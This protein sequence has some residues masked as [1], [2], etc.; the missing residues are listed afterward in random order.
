MAGLFGVKTQST[1]DKRLNAIDV[2]QSAYGAVIAL[3]YG[4]TRVPINLLWY[5]SFVATPHTTKQSGGKGGG[6]GSSNT[7]FTYS[8]AMVL[9]LGEGQINGIGT[10]WA[11]KA[12]TTLTA[13][14]L[15]LFTG[16]GG[17]AVW[18]Y[19]TT[20]FPTQ[21]IGYDHTAYVASGS[22]QLGNSAAVPNLSFELK[23]LQLFNPGTIDDAEPSDVLIDYC[24]DANHGCGFPYLSGLQGAGVTTYESYCIAMGMFISPSE[25]TQRLASEFID[26]ILQITNS[27]AVQSPGQLRIVPYADA[28]VTGNGRTYTPDLTPL[29]SFNDDDF[30]PQED[31]DPVKVTRKPKIERFNVV[32]VEYLNRDNQYNVDV[33]EAKDQADI[34]VNGERVAPTINLHS[35]TVLALAR[36]VAQ[37]LLQRQLY[38]VNAYW[39]QVRADY[40]LLEPMDYVS[41]TD[42][43]LGLTNKLVRILEVEDDEDDVLTFDVE[44]VLVGTA[45]APRYN[46]QDA[47]GYAANYSASP[48]SIATPLIFNA[49]PM[50]VDTNGGYEL[51]IAAHGANAN[52]AGCDV[53]MSLDGA[54]YVF[55]GTINGPAR[56]GTLTATQASSPDPDTTNTLAVQLA[57]STLALVSGT[58]TD[59]Q[60][61]RTLLY[62]DGEIEAY[63]TATLTGAGAYNITNLR[64][65]VYGSAVAS[66]ASASKF[67]RIDAAIFRV[68]YDAG[69][70]G[71]TASFK[72]CSFNVFGQG[73]ESIASVPAYTKVLTAANA[74]QLIPGP[75]TLV[76]RGVTIMGD[77]A[78]KSAATSAW[79]SD[80]YSA[81]GYTNGAFVSFR[82]TQP[83]QRFMIALN[84]DPTTDAS[85]TSLDYALHPDSAGLLEIY[86]SNAFIG[87]FG[88]YAVGDDL[89]IVYDGA[90]VRYL[91]N[92]AV[93]REVMAGPG[94]L[95]YLDSSF[96][97]PGAAVS[98]MRFGPYGTAAPVLYNARGNCIVSDTNAQKVG[99]SVAWDSDVYSVKGFPSCHVFFKPNDATGRFVV[100]LGTAPLADLSYTSVN[101][102]WICNAGSGLQIYE[103][104]SYIGSYGGYDATTALAITYDAATITYWLNGVS[105]RTVSV[106]G[107][108][109]YLDSSFEDAGAGCNSLRFG[110]TTN[111]AV[112]DTSQ[113]GLN[114]AFKSYIATGAGG[115]ITGS[116][117]SPT[118][119]G[120][121][122]VPAQ[123]FDSTVVVTYV[124]NM[125]V[126]AGTSG[127]AGTWGYINTTTR[128]FYDATAGNARVYQ[129]S[130]G[131]VSV[132]NVTIEETFSLPANTSAT[133]YIFGVQS[134]GG[135]G[136]AGGTAGW[137]L[138]AEVMFR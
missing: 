85:W 40:C 105:V 102:G 119:I 132:N 37:L 65:G 136:R 49:P 67:A 104:G 73:Y 109:L 32:R 83:N 93:L 35:I 46:W 33:A 118:T 45:G 96:Y 22:L 8:A 52:W 110:P 19:L 66:H 131:L 113:I 7:T 133:Y 29:F 89:S 116:F 12:Q 98:N 92:G 25:R 50:L 128:P 100:G 14:G 31:G 2:N 3:T 94:K 39:F 54:S 59:Y 16:A 56:Y 60:N 1:I 51:W 38:V 28:S 122:T 112:A 134:G 87:F 75:L 71:Q 5:G 77:K 43:G 23:G 124:S 121:V 61:L 30:L 108:T 111:L 13:L 84:S 126:T 76:G 135:T 48:G 44:E 21:A 107:L 9:A 91:K 36:L 97:D 55:I 86:E 88:S 53:Y 106:A 69:M 58:A 4:K 27:Q 68:P 6:G 64:R 115:A 81:Q 125:N 95:F 72:F 103:S 114:A 130:A 70:I 11:D 82:P 117:A 80:V 101:Y 62:V 15:T 74:G 63:Q 10:V 18:S 79:D 34:S 17:Q 24:T 127:G 57:N 99:G 129:P 138:K 20:N 41:I 26:E 42:A 47:Q 137:V 123:P 90:I 120:S 78:F